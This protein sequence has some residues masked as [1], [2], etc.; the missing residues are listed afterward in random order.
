M[1]AYK[2]TL[3]PHYDVDTTVAVPEP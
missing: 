1:M 2:V 3:G